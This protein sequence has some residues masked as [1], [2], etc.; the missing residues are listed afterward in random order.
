MI[1][2]RETDCKL[3]SNTIIT[4]V[5]VLVA[6]MVGSVEAIGLLDSV[7]PN[8]KPWRLVRRFKNYCP[9]EYRVTA[10]FVLTGIGYILV[11]KWRRFE[12]IGVE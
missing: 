8:G 6:F 3:Y 12:Q 9:R 5:S 2:P 11:Y 4:S 7:S 10:I 1:R